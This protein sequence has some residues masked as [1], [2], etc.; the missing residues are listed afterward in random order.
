MTET[1]P[2]A[3]TF[4]NGIFELSQ[5]T[6]GNL[7]LSAPLADAKFITH[8][9]VTNF[10]YF[11]GAGY[12]VTLDYTLCTNLTTASRKG[13]LD[14]VL[15]LPTSAPG[16]NVTVTNFPATQPVSFTQPISVTQST[17]PWVVS[18]TVAATQGTTPW[19]TTSAMAVPASTDLVGA[20]RSTT[21]V[22]VTIP[23]GRI[24]EGSVSLSASVS[25][26][27]NSQPTISI[28]GTGA[29]PSGTIHSI[30]VV[31]LALTALCNSNTQSNVFIFGGTGGAAVTFT[32]GASGTSTGQITG[33]LL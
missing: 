32:Q 24:F 30:I 9:S 28:S 14:A 12:A 8:P 26:L 6:N 13:Q 16:T 3:I 18:G 5:P 25:V 33:R 7:V 19:V 27:G 22:L 29:L 2:F 21:G 4:T 1:F 10:Y 17:S 15:A 23:A 20:S 31:G 11:G